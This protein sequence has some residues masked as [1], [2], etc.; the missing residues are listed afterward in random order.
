MFLFLSSQ[1]SGSVLHSVASLPFLSSCCPGCNSQARKEH[2]SERQSSVKWSETSFL[3]I[4]PFPLKKDVLEDLCLALILLV[5]FFFKHQWYNVVWSY[6]N[7]KPT[8][9][10]HRVWEIATSRSPHRGWHRRWR[11]PHVEAGRRGCTISR[12]SVQLQLWPR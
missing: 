4:C 7:V 3:N 12:H 5:F 1:R 9:C 8:A 10:L 11:D 6:V 2:V